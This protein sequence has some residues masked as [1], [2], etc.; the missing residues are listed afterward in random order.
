MKHRHFPC[1]TQNQPWTGHHNFQNLEEGA[2][3]HSTKSLPTRNGQQKRWL[4]VVEHM[5]Y[6]ELSDRRWLK[7][8]M[9]NA[10]LMYCTDLSER[11][12]E[13]VKYF[14]VL[15]LFIDMWLIITDFCTY[16]NFDIYWAASSI[17]FSWFFMISF[18]LQF[19]LNLYYTFLFSL[20]IYCLL[21]CSVFYPSVLISHVFYINSVL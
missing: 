6:R 20:C 8:P 21:Y 15:Y 19:Y 5:Y 16:S 10:N 18:V 12:S 9:L 13:M 7:H 11:K 1:E 17:N 14:S 3:E 2:K 4:P